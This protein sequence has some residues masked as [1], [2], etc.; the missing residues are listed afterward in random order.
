[1]F[2]SHC[3]DLAYSDF[4]GYFKLSTEDRLTLLM[5]VCSVKFVI[6]LSGL[7][8]ASRDLTEDLNRHA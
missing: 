3:E 1:M 8:T 6:L 2:R 4:L 5:I 7:E